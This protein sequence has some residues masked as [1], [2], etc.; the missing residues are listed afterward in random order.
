MVETGSPVQTWKK[1]N[2][3]DFLFKHGEREKEFNLY[4]PTRIVIPQP[5]DLFHSC[6]FQQNPSQNGGEV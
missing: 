3:N 6:A 2:K 1:L 5:L 4:L